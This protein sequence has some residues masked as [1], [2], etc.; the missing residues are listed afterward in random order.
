[1]TIP[2]NAAHPPR[3]A[4]WSRRLAA[5]ADSRLGARPHPAADTGRHPKRCGPPH[6]RAGRTT[7]AERLAARC[8]PRAR[9]GTV[10]DMNATLILIPHGR[11]YA[12]SRRGR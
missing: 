7:T 6:L 12:D 11:A 3:S 5:D 4:T 10:D 2:D 9:N 8:G 1:V